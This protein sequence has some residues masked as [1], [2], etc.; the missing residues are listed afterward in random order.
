MERENVSLMD[1]DPFLAVISFLVF[2]IHAILIPLKMNRGIY[3]TPLYVICILMHND[4]N[5]AI[6]LLIKSTSSINRNW[7]NIMIINT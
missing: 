3:G 7:I 2:I 4:D 6:L 5:W 1:E